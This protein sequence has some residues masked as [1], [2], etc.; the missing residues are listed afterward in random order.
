MALLFFMI[1]VDNNL[2]KEVSN[3]ADLSA[4]KRMNHNFHNFPDDPLQRMLNAIEPTTYVRPH[5]HENPD[6]REVF[7]ILKGKALVI[8]F[9]PEGNI[10]EYFILNYDTGNVACEINCRIFHTII[11]L[12]KN[13]V[14]YELKEGPYCPVNDKNFAQWAPEEYTNEAQIFIDDLLIK[15]DITI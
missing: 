4:R 6:K 1:K 12:E 8:E 2:L 5:K 9:T 3:K 10:S 14:V 13:T 15:L 11:S 7:V